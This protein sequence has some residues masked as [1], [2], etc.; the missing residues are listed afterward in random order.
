MPFHA[1]PV[2]DGADGVTA[3]LAELEAASHE[4]VTVFTAG[5]RHVIVYRVKPRPGRP[6]KVETR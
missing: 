2:A 4:I 6:K 3:M 5:D 1:V